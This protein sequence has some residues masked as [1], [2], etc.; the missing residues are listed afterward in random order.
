MLYNPLIRSIMAAEDSVE[1][2]C[3]QFELAAN[4]QALRISET[5]PGI[6]RRITGKSGWTVRK[7]KVGFAWL[8]WRRVTQT[9]KGRLT[10]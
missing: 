8:S 5:G 1:R 3:W 9:E 6:L 10:K 4:N 7:L 2:R